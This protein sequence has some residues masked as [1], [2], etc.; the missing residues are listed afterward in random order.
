MKSIT[1]H[2]VMWGR[3]RTLRGDR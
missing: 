2:V 3:R 1:V